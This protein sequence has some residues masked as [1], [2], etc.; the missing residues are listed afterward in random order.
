LSENFRKFV[1]LFRQVCKHG[2]ER[3]PVFPILVFEIK[4]QNKGGSYVMV[5]LL[6]LSSEGK[7]FIEI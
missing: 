7:M 3:L 2:L 4:N 6:T 1:R 5:L